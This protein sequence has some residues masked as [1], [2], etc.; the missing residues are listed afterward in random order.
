M[1]KLTLF[2]CLISAATFGQNDP[3]FQQNSVKMDTVLINSYSHEN[4]KNKGT[5]RN[6]W[7]VGEKVS[8]I[9]ETEKTLLFGYLKE[10]IQQKIA[11][12]NTVGFYQNHQD[13]YFRVNDL[14]ALRKQ[15]F[16]H[17]EQPPTQ[18]IETKTNFKGDNIEIL[19]KIGVGMIRDKVSPMIE[20]LIGVNFWE[21][22]KPAFWKN[23][24]VGWQPYFSFERGSDGNYLINRNDFVYLAF[25]KT[26][27]SRGIKSQEESNFLDLKNWRVGLGYLVRQEGNYFQGNTYKLFFQT[28]IKS[29]ISIMPELIFTNDFKQIYP[30]IT[31]QF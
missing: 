7:A 14:E 16:K 2:L 17:T 18:Y 24:Q 22:K 20:V 11:G 6:I 26:F 3:L 10:E 12:F 5:K 8:S 29:K 25:G 27:D 23:F 28:R 1:K 9:S 4:P 30:S 21:N 31:I 15:N 19:G 13:L